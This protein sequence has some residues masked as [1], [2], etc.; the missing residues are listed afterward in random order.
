MLNLEEFKTALKK[1]KL[2]ATPQ[3]LAV[4]KAMMELVHASADDVAGFILLEGKTKI[5]TAS[6]YNILKQ[7][8]GL[9]IYR[10]RLSADSKMYF[11]LE[12]GKHVHLYD[13]VNHELMD[14]QEDEVIALAESYFRGRRFRGYKVDGVEIQLI[15]HPSGK[16]KTLF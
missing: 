11:D 7:L 8:A 2:K 15:C 16:K 13:K 9:G 10:L 1:K 12:T 6:V 4:H 14:L 3:R 5:T